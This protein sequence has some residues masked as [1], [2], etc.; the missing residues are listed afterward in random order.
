MTWENV[1]W[2]RE[3]EGTGSRHHRLLSACQCLACILETLSYVLPTGGLRAG[4]SL[5]ISSDA[6]MEAEGRG[7]VWGA[8]IICP[9]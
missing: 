6:E 1:Q 5:L 3:P 8:L 9:R 4:W 2:Q 7:V